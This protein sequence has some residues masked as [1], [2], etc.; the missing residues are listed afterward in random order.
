MQNV[1][2]DSQKEEGSESSGDND[3]GRSVPNLIAQRTCYGCKETHHKRQRCRFWRRRGS[4][5]KVE[6]ID[7]GTKRLLD[8]LFHVLIGGAS[9]IIITYLGSG[10]RYSTYVAQ[11]GISRCRFNDDLML[12]D[13]SL[14]DVE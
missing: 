3:H 5:A 2:Y 8:C 6:I 7:L 10:C 12:G 13:L 4:E 14:I 11:Y 9:S 1:E